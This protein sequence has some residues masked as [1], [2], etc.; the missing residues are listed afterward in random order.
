MGGPKEDLVQGARS[1]LSRAWN[2]LAPLADPV[3]AQG[4]VGPVAGLEGRPDAEPDQGPLG[5]IATALRRAAEA[6]GEGVAVL[7]VDLPRVPA[8]LFLALARRWRELE[9]PEDR[10][11]VVEGNGGLQPLVGVYGTGLAA[12]LSRWLV[13][14]GS[15]AVHAWIEDLGDRA[16]RVPL[17]EVAASVG[18]DDVLLNLNRPGDLGVAERLPRAAPP[19]V[20]V[21]G[22]KDAGKTTVAVAL[23]GA[24]RE[25]G[26]RVMALKH[27]HGFDLDTPGTDSHRLSHEAGAERVLLAGPERM[28]LLGT[29]GGEG[30]LDAPAL[31]ARYLAEAD[32]VVAEGW[33]TASLPAIEVVREAPAEPALWDDEA[34]DRDRF[35]ARVVPDGAMSTSLAP[36]HPATFDRN[37]PELAG[38]L[39]RLVEARIVPGWRP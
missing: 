22:W 13:E 14:G 16:V 17:A 20:S 7:A 26:W 37:D 23:V 28:A 25:R 10:A 11:V 1:L 12:P 8:S 39:V 4:A 15:R 9:A 33:R 2:A 29:W 34:P 24:L 6:G 35:L 32:V 21:V 3:V 36:G 38:H 18:H 5:G 19:M 30:E 31:A 27:G